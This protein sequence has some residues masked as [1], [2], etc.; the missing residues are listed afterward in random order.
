[1]WSPITGSATLLAVASDLKYIARQL[2]KFLNVKTWIYLLHVD[3]TS[4]VRIGL[5]GYSER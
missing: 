1:M 3:S 4:L 2:S 5:L